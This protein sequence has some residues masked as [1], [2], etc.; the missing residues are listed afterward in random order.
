[1]VLV[2]FYGISFIYL[3]VNGGDR[4]PWVVLCKTGQ[5]LS[6]LIIVNGPFTT[7]GF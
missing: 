7:F 2:I 1:M 4:V 6:V 5:D 3:G